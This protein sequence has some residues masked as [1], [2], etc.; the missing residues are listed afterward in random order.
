M[1]MDVALGS[2]VVSFAVIA[3]VMWAW[4]ALNWLWLKPKRLERCLRE[5]GLSG[6]PYRVF[7]GDMKE[8]RMIVKEAKSRPINLSDDILPRAMPFHHHI[9]K[10][11]GKNSFMWV[12]P[13][14][15]V[16]IMEPELI[17]EI[18]SKNDIFKKAKP[19]PL[20]RLL[21]GGIAFY[22]DEQWAKHRRILNPAFHME[23]LKNML[24]SMYLCCSEMMSKWEMLLS[25]K[26]SCDLDVQSYLDNLTGDVISRTAFGSSYEEGR[27]LFELQKEQAELTRQI[28]QSVYIPGWRFLPTKINKRMKEINNELVAIMTEMINKRERSMKLGVAGQ[29]DDLLSLLLTSNMREIQEHGNNKDMGM[30]FEEV[31]EDCKAFYFAGQ[32]STS[33]FLLWTMVL[34]SIHPEWQVRAREEVWKTFQNNKPDF[35]GLNHLKIVTMIMNEVLRLYP[36]AA[37]VI[38][39]IHK[40]TKLGNMT[41][42]PGIELLLPI[43]LVHGD[44]DIWGKDA[45]KFKPERFSQGIANATKNQQ[46]SYLPFSWGPRICIANNFALIEAKLALVMILQRFSFKLSPSYTHAPTYAVNLRPQHG[47]HLTLSKI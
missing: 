17:K 46:V 14:P 8:M 15:R 31:I 35:D 33:N 9:I 26:S 5:Q 39:T 37:T 10:K 30:S 13:V 4:R 12:G 28:V 20:A 40:D 3:L 24:P 22:E 7:Y 19:N 25:E 1:K 36:P 16:N 29:D 43:I 6:N 23:K 38:R 45:T 21:I 44:H 32:E 18:L 2:I 41:L 47:A 11:Y 27:T 34:L 42:P